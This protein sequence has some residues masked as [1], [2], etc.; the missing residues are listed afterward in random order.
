MSR[1]QAIWALHIGRSVLTSLFILGGINK[2]SDPTAVLVQIEAGGLPVPSLVL[3]LVIA[4]EPGG[5]LW[6]ASGLRGTGLMALGL[7]GYT[8]LVNI[9]FHA[10]W[11]VPTD[12]FGTELSLFFKNI[13]VAGGLVA[14]AGVSVLRRAA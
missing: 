14:M 13:A 7:A 4:L 5:G 3:V 2:L 1:V 9:L 12:N 11:A 8:L 6:V 10:F